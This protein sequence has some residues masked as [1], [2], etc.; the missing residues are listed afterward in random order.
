M[1][2]RKTGPAGALVL[3]DIDGTLLRRAGPHHR[4]ALVAAIR[5]VTGLDTT[6]D[7]IP[8]HGMLD[9]DIITLMMRAAGAS[10]AL[11]RRS[12]P[13]VSRSAEANYVRRCPGLERKVCPGVRRLLW[14]LS[15]RSVPLGLVTGNLPRIGW[16][17][18]ER[19]G[20]K[21]HFRLG[22][23]A[24]M[25]KDRA[26]LVRNAVR[27]ARRL[28]LILPDA[29]ISLIGDAPADVR[30][31]LATGVQSIAVSTGISTPEELAAESPHLLLEDLRSLPFERL[32]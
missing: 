24:G 19:A 18:L 5:R 9:P 27:E 16:K 26:G 11:I 22:A 23:F 32:F 28:G 6:T 20:L 4:E 31:A 14:R 15:R 3:F 7:G 17:K 29:K 25:S 30:A 8:V 12:M 1:S 13:D 10:P 2:P 21:H